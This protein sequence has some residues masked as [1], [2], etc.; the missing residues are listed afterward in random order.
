[1]EILMIGATGQFAGLVVPQLKK[2]GLTVHALV[3]DEKKGREALENGANQ[4]VTGSLYDLNSLL[5]AAEGK[6][7]IFH[8]IPAFQKEVKAGLNMV[9]AASK[10]GVKK[11][12]F[13]SV[14]HPS[15]SLVNHAEKRPAEEALYDRKWTIPSCNLQCTC[16]C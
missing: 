1:M 13:S 5:K 2:Q 6:D 7:G 9:N 3:Q 11:F 10:A 14:Y 12:V 15:L 16:R 8:I 4:F